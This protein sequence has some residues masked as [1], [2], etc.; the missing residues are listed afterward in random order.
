MFF[1]NH[2]KRSGLFILLSLF[3]HML[4]ILLV[5]IISENNKWLEKEKIA[6]FIT[7]NIDIPE[8][9][10]E[11]EIKKE[12]KSGT[13]TARKVL[14]AKALTSEINNKEEEKSTEPSKTTPGNIPSS[15]GINKDMPP[16]PIIASGYGIGMPGLG[17]GMP[18]G[19]GFGGAFGG[20]RGG[21]DGGMGN[22]RGTGIGNGYG[23]MTYE[24]YLALCLKII[25]KNKRYPQAALARQMEGKVKAQIYLNS[26]GSVANVSVLATSGWDAL[27]SEALEC[28]K[29]AS[30]F[31]PPPEG[32]LN[33]GMALLSVTIE[34]QIT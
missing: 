1:R 26:N 24:G 13:G 12:I 29:R 14:S 20:G 9:K 16:A 19:G 10:P 28:I 6:D 22:G 31:P 32:I 8:R 33:N 23:N 2:D 25:E 4:F 27:D 7:L 30:P 18:G 34:F 21:N 3:L 17:S 5:F 11:I 15:M